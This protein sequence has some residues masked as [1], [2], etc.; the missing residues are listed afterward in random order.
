MRLPRFRLTTRSLMAIVAVIAVVLGV[1]VSIV[2][3]IQR[4]DAY[5]S[6]A[7]FHASYEQMYRMTQVQ[8]RQMAYTLE[9]Q[10]PAAPGPANAV[11]AEDLRRQAAETR[12]EALSNGEYA[13]YH[14]K[15]REK[16]LRG[17][18]NPWRELEPDP[19]PPEPQARAT[20][21]LT[22]RQ[23]GPALEAFAEG[24]KRQPKNAN[25]HNEYAWRLATCPV[26]KFRD[27]K[28]AV[29][30]A[31]TACTLTKWSDPNLVDTLAAAYAEA[32]RFAEAVEW[33]QRAL[34]I[35][36]ETHP[37]RPG[38]VKRLELFEQGKTYQEDPIP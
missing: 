35:L 18:A 34:E 26:A 27:G 5:Q 37:L 17:V 10:I 28:K 3:T 36:P 33:Q 19:P 6:L 20:F 7:M 2:Q 11:H 14:A 30:L 24:V 8:Q 4:R 23:Y 31:T 25:I 12:A 22:R 15:L 16:Y 32:G 29:P 1:G 9:S 13:D 21:Y 38:F